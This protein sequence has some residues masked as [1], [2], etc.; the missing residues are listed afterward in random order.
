MVFFWFPRIDIFL[1]LS[2][3]FSKTT[4]PMRL[5]SHNILWKNE[6]GILNRIKND[7]ILPGET[8]SVGSCQAQKI[9]IGSGWEVVGFRLADPTGIPIKYDRILSDSDDIRTGIRPSDR[10]SWAFCSSKIPRYC[11]YY[12][13]I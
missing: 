11:G 2:A 8:R 5:R 13:G 12:E 6:D 4:T 9:S 3:F 10:M 7:D 1:L